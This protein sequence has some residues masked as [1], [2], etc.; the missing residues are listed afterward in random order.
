MAEQ[1]VSVTVNAPVRQVYGL[2][3]HF[4]DFPKFMTYVKEV[5]Y[6]DT[7]KSHWVADIL[8]RHE[9]DAVNEDWIED[10]QVGWRSIAGFENSGRVTFQ[11]VGPMQTLVD[12]YINYTP[13][14]GVLGDIVEDLGA[15]QHF[16][17]A[18]QHD[19]DNFAKM[20]DQTPPGALDPT[21]SNYLFQSDSAA[22]TGTTTEEQDR[23]MG[24]ASTTDENYSSGQSFAAS[25]DETIDRPVLDADIIGAQP[26]E[27]EPP[28]FPELPTEE[29]KPKP[30]LEPESGTGF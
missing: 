24:S 8:G 25:P 7:N 5:T 3:T 15:G 13:P 16:K 1:H 2:F 23:T 17:D 26:T 18:L 9:W 21:S 30:V 28:T 19:M 14:A 6:F 29:E 11:E 22:A 10:R 4:N 20:V 12:V 27:I